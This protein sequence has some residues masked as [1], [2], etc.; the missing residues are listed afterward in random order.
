MRRAILPSG[1][2]AYLQILGTNERLLALFLIGLPFLGLYGT[3]FVMSNSFRLGFAAGALGNVAPR[4]GGLLCLHGIPELAAFAVGAAAVQGMA[5]DALGSLTVGADVRW[6]LW[7]GLLLLA[8]ACLPVTA[9][10]E[11][12]SIRMAAGGR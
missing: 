5:C 9:C 1:R 4:L 6:K 7:G 2:A 12:V 10:L 3:M 8:A 11:L